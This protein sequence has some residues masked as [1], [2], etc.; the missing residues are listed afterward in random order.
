MKD[1]LK[2][3]LEIPTHSGEESL[4]RDFIIK[5]GITHGIPV[6]QDPKGNVYLK[7]GVLLEDEKY[8][9]VMAHMDTV[10]FDQREL[11][12]TKTKIKVVEVITDDGDT[13]YMG[14]NPIEDT[15]TGIGGDDK[16]GVAICLDIILKTDKIIGAFFVEEEIGC[17]GSEEM[18]LEVLKDVG[19]AIEFD[20]PS[21]NWCS[22]I[23]NNVPLFDLAFFKR[24][25]PILDKFGITNIRVSDPF[26]DIHLVP[27]L[28][29]V[30][31]INLFA[32]YHQMH[33]PSE[34][35]VPDHV[36]KARDV[37]IDIIKEFGFNEFKI[38]VEYKNIK[39]LY[40][41]IIGKKNIN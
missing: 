27:R 19:Y 28:L 2:E 7:K 21:D 36:E 38:D 18:D 13:A 14:V 10:H 9:L 23:S 1:L 5:F 15:L 26:T 12:N 29:E 32:G 35:V 37:G 4:V 6:I 31:S 16:A 22:F 25:E 30:N 11:I 24:V 33:S 20:A 39:I 3:V 34:Y 8:P 40:E 17:L 41:T